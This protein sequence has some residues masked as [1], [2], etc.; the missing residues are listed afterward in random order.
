[1]LE[2]IIITLG[3]WGKLGQKLIKYVEGGKTVKGKLLKILPLLFGAV[4]LCTI[5]SNAFG[6][7]TLY[8]PQLSGILI[9]SGLAIPFGVIVLSIFLPFIEAIRSKLF[10]KRISAV[11]WIVGIV[12]SGLLLFFSLGLFVFGVGGLSCLPKCVRANLVSGKIQFPLSHLDGI[13]IDHN[14]RIYLAISNYSRI[15]V[16]TN[17][18]D[19]SGGW[20]INSRG[21][22][23]DIWIDD[24]DLLHA[25]VARGGGHQVYDL[26]GLPLRWDEI[27]S[28]DDEY[29]RLADKLGGLRKKDALG[30]IYL[31][32]S[33]IWSPRIVKITTTGEETILIK[34]AIYFWLV[35]SPQP[36]W[37]VSLAG[38]I[39]SIILGVIIKVKGNF[40]DFSN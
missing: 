40:S 27:T 34:D 22:S 24:E 2:R 7:F 14:G 1:M 26:N 35:Q 10:P 28:S 16:Y 5:L 37:L 33:P 36:I 39:M 3:A 38:L 11:A 13:A 8:L 32:R 31:I 12:F 4:L 17:E 9:I 30:N 23:V 18:G 20:F 29:L 6:F 21:A 15:Q 19:F 25:V